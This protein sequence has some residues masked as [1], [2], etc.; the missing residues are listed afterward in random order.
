MVRQ[1]ETPEVWF[2]VPI[3]AWIIMTFSRVLVE[4][5]ANNLSMQFNSLSTKP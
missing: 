5:K 2:D 3:T 1:V 4:D